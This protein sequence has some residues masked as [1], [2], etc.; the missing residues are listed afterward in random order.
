RASLALK[1]EIA[2]GRGPLAAGRVPLAML[3]CR[4][5]LRQWVRAPC[6]EPAPRLK[7]GYTLGG[8]QGSRRLRCG[9]LG[10]LGSF[11][12]GQEDGTDLDGG[13]MLAV[14]FEPAVVLAPAEVLD[15]ELGG[16]VVHDLGQDAGAFDQRPADERAL[17]ALAEQDAVECQLGPDLGVAIVQAD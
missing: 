3:D 5:P 11:H 16:R 13:V 17:A 7:S 15:V 12:A 4:I 1:M 6:R 14:S 8:R 2:N 10:G 9:S